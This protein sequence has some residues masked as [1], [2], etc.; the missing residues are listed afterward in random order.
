M[1]WAN[2]GPIIIKKLLNSLAISVSATISVLSITIFEGKDDMSILLFQ[3]R[4]FIMHHVLLASPRNLISFPE[5]KFFL[6]F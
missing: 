1:F 4:S 2:F 6:N 5:Y 3:I